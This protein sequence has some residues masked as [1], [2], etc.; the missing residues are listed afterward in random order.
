MVFTQKLCWVFSNLILIFSRKADFTWAWFDNHLFILALSHKQGTPLVAVQLEM[1]TT[2]LLHSHAN[3]FTKW[4]TKQYEQPGIDSHHSQIP[5][6]LHNFLDLVSPYDVPLYRATRVNAHSPCVGCQ[7][8]VLRYGKS[9]SCEISLRERLTL[10]PFYYCHVGSGCIRLCTDLFWQ[11]IYSLC[12][13]EYHWCFF[14][15]I[16]QNSPLLKS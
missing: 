7:I 4:I 2:L 1:Y 14:S 5:L 15:K 16:Y 11:R 10:T 12:Y 3:N 6:N 8:T 13:L 9:D